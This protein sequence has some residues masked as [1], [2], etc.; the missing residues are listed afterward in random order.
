MIGNGKKAM[1]ATT[2][3]MRARAIQSW[4]EDFAR[5][6]APRWL[7]IKPAL[8]FLPAWWP[9]SNSAFA[10]FQCVFVG[11]ALL[12]AP[13]EVRAYLLAHELA[14]VRRRHTV[15]QAVY[16]VGVA[17]A[18]YLSRELAPKF[19]LIP[20]VAVLG[21]AALWLFGG[22]ER[23]ELEADDDAATVCGDTAVIN[24]LLWM[25]RRRDRASALTAKR[26]A[27]RR[28]NLGSVLRAAEGL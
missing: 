9:W 13:R 8:F 15:G 10:Y 14:H 28:E 20:F 25:E 24:G 5:L 23:R 17:A 1:N 7:L 19:A 18:W 2:P 26:L 11:P 21:L 22:E 6:A 4:R 27:R 3:A 12:R 16:W